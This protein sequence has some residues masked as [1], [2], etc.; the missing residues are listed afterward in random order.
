MRP[1]VV[2]FSSVLLNAAVIT[3]RVQVHD[4]FIFT[5]ADIRMFDMELIV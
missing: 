5:Q 3:L 2:N 1:D 4:Q